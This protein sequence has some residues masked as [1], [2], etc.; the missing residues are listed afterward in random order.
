MLNQSIADIPIPARMARRPINQRGFPIPWFVGCVK[1]EYDFRAIDPPKLRDAY[2]R[3]LCWLCGEPL[4][5][6][7]AFVIGPMCSVN[8]VSSEPPSHR[9]CAEYAVRACPF[10]SKPRMRRNEVD[11]PEHKSMPGNPVMH[12]PG[13]VLIWITRRYRIVPV[14]GGYLFEI[15]EPHE[16]QWFAEGKRANRSQIMAAMDKGLPLL[17]AEARKEGTG[18]EVELEA[19]VERAMK[20]VPAE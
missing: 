11:L 15:G 1:G 4:G 14:T 16:L 12:N 8:R 19:Q 3:K 13:A 2:R 5:R 10:L 7:F 17:R 9:D 6:Y 20:L 18:A